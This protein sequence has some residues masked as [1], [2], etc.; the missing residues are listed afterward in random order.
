MR[1]GES[2][3]I[4]DSPK[5]VASE[6]PSGPYGDIDHPSTPTKTDRP[7]PDGFNRLDGLHIVLLVRNSDEQTDP[8]IRQWS[9]FGTQTIRDLQVVRLR[10]IKGDN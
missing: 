2:I 3:R 4:E 6:D 8:S 1:A 9:S 7:S 5:S 10:A